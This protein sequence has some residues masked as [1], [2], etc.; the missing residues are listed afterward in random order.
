[1]LLRMQHHTKIGNADDPHETRLPPERNLEPSSARSLL[2]I[3][4]PPSLEYFFGISG[5]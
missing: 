3:L 5:P 2:Y 4:E 1:M